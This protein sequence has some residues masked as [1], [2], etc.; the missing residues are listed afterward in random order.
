M[1]P[2]AAENAVCVGLE[3]VLIPSTW[4]SLSWNFELYS[5]NEE[6]WL[7]QPSVKARTK[8]ERTT[9]FFPLNWL[10][11][12]CRRLWSASAKSGAGCPTFGTRRTS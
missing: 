2:S 4:V 5:R 9:F 12:I 1:P 8:K 10:R 6:I 11:V 7:V 3:S